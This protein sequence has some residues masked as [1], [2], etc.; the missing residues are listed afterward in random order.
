MITIGTFSKTSDG[1]FHGAIRTL[2][3]SVKA[4][5]I[6]PSRAP[7]T[8]PPTTGTSPAR[9]RSGPPG[10]S[11]TPA[12]RNACRCASTTRASPPRRTRCW[13]RSR[14]ATSCAGRDD[15]RPE[16]AWRP[17]PAGVALVVRLRPLMGRDL[18]RRSA[19]EIGAPLILAWRVRF[20]FLAGRALRAP[21][22]KGPAAAGAP[23]A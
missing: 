12:S 4:L 19:G 3:F 20:D 21:R 11:L 18:T 1:A 5:E 2:T 17:R 16:R 9:P 7:T 13:P 15:L 6:R 10:R 8:R 23:T 14:T 22:R